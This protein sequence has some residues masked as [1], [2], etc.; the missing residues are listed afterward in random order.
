MREKL[1]DAA[2]YWLITI[3]LVIGAWNIIPYSFSLDNPQTSSVTCV[4]IDKNVEQYEHGKHHR[5][6]STRYVMALKPVDQTKFHNFDTYVSF[7]TYSSYNTGDHITFP[8]MPNSKC[9]RS[10]KP[11][12]KKTLYAFGLFVLGCVCAVG[13]LFTGITGACKLFE[14]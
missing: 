1:F 13:S 5:N 3:V 9:L 14:N 2:K 10:Y 7:S 4:V 11:N 8:E 12:H 6:M